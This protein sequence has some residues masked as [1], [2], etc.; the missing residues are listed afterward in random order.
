M[1][2]AIIICG[3]PADKPWAEQIV[4]AL[5]RFGVTSEVRVASAHKTPDHLRSML[6]DYERRNEHHVYITIAGRS[7]ALSGFVDAA[8]TAPVIA[9]PPPSDAFSGMDI[10]SSLRMP[11][12]VAPLVVLE[13]ENAALAAAKILALTNHEL[14]ATVAE[15]QEAERQRIV[16][17]DRERGEHIAA[18]M[19][20]EC[21]VIGVRAP[22]AGALA[23]LGLHALQHRGQESAGVATFDGSIHLHKAMGLVAQVFAAAPP[24]PGS[25]AVGH[26]RYSTT[27]SSC[28]ANAGPFY[29][30]TTLGPL[31]VAHNGNIVNVSE[32]RAMLASHYSLTPISDSDSELLTLLLQVAPGDTWVE[33]LRWMAKQAHGSYALVL[34]TGECLIGVRDPLGI[35]PLAL[36]RLADGWALASESCAFSV[37]GGRFVRDLAPGEILEIGPMGPV[38]TRFIA[39]LPPA[40]HPAFCVFEYIY[41]ARPDTLFAGRPVHAVRR[42]M[43]EQLA[44]EHPAA[45]DLVIGVPDSGTSAALG[46]AS[47]S[48][49]PFGEGLIKN[50]YIGRTFIQPTQAERERLIR[51][52]FG[53]LPLKGKR[54]VLV[55]DSIVRGNTMRPIVALLREAEA[56]EVHV[57]VACPPITHPCYF[58]VDMASPKELIANRLDEEAIAAYVGA[59]SLHYLSIAG[60][61][62]AIRGSN[63]EFH[64]REDQYEGD[65]CLACLTGRYPLPVP[66]AEP[67]SSRV[68][69]PAPHSRP[70]ATGST[71]R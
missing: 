59:D 10:L 44:Y 54:V 3:S 49:I 17:A 20:D 45:A 47:A 11:R 52:K 4:T 2:K 62:R 42:A 5:G 12:G 21:G 14:R 27:G 71:A 32:I 50:R 48:G 30:E 7:N 51:M 18:K 31:V 15:E 8:V 64:G 61:L 29:V 24:L 38:G 46:Y 69:V 28:Q 63:A 55:D 16:D 26:N 36:G 70:L 68:P 41:L 43:G 33:R 57:R 35:R 60:L 58:G 40:A 19:H 67:R 9:C 23:V 25:W 56:A 13:A 37:I 39:P 66:A 34:L 22:D 1:A 6:A 53:T 65:H